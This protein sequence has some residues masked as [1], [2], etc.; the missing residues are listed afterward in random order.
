VTYYLFFLLPQIEEWI[1]PLHFSCRDDRKAYIDHPIWNLDEEIM[2]SGCFVPT[3]K[4]QLSRVFRS[5]PNLNL[6]RRELAQRH[7]K[8]IDF[9]WERFSTCIWPPPLYTLEDRDRKQSTTPFTLSFSS[10]TSHSSLLLHE[11]WINDDEPL[12]RS[13]WLGFMISRGHLSV[14]CFR[15]LNQT[16]QAT[17]LVYCTHRLRHQVKCSSTNMLLGIPIQSYSPFTH[18]VNAIQWL[19]ISV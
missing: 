4:N 19:A 6:I 15:A 11:P 1:S 14:S 10:T 9:V 3:W 5:M 7:E 17:W 12:E 16:P 18:H 8:L 2:A 13:G